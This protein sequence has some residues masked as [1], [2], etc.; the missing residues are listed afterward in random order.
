MSHVLLAFVAL[1]QSVVAVSGS[2][3]AFGQEL[4]CGSI[5][6]L[7]DRSSLNSVR[8]TGKTHP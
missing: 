7:N 5:W 3:E 1:V 6:H 4:L 2:H 8:C